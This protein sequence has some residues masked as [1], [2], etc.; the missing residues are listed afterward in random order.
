MP[1]KKKPPVLLEELEAKRVPENGHE[2]GELTYVSKV[3]WPT[4]KKSKVTGVGRVPR[5]NNALRM[6]IPV[7]ASVL[8]AAVMLYQFAPSKTDFNQEVSNV[9][10]SLSTVSTQLSYEAGRIDN[11]VG[12]MGTYALKDELAIY[13]PTS[14]VTSLQTSLQVSLE[15]LETELDEFR[16]TLHDLEA[17]IVLLEE[18]D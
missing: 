2:K 17:R 7:L 13:A 3:A 8:L 1:E 14:T 6:V 15:A 4:K 10:N 12:K 18:V 11:I 5:G 9:R 16:L